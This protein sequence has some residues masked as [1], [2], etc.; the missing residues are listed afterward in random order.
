MTWAKYGT[1]FF[2]QMVD[3]DFRPD[4]DD[5]V[6]LTHTQAL[7]YLYS[8]ESLEMVF[9][10]STLRRF[11]TSTKAED[12]AHELVKHGLWVDQGATFRVVHHEDVFRQSLAYQLKERNRSKASM[13]KRRENDK[14]SLVTQEVTQDVTRNVMRT[15]TDSQTDNQS[16]D[17]K[18]S[19][20]AE[21]AFNPE[22]GEVLP[23]EEVPAWFEQEEQARS[24]ESGP[25]PSSKESTPEPQDDRSPDVRPNEAEGGGL[26]GLAPEV[27][28]RW[29]NRASA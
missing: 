5:A 8:V 2:D 15:Q 12:A 26:N 1:E 6:Q 25:L 10:K 4:L 20:N 16:L 17:M 19:P 23:Q 28:D 3:T 24:T 21:E 27:V 7:H 18:V 9:K 14:E 13:R 11:A 29:R 22:T